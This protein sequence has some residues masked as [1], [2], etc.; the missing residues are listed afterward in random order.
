MFSV[1]SIH[2]SR[3]FHQIAFLQIVV[4]LNYSITRYS[5]FATKHF[6]TF[7]VII[8]FSPFLNQTLYIFRTIQAFCYNSSYLWHYTFFDTQRLAHN[9]EIKSN[10]ILFSLT[11]VWRSFVRFFY[12]FNF[13]RCVSLKHRYIVHLMSIRIHILHSEELGANVF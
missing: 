5:P 2:W 7:Y 12:T 1:V 13:Y 3:Q 10:S 9:I 8:I 4:E 6:R 11:I